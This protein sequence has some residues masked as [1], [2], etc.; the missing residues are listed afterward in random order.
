MR[1]YRFSVALLA[2]V[3]EKYTT[4]G[5]PG[6]VAASS[7]RMKL[8]EPSDSATVSLSCRPVYCSMCGS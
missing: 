3:S 8:N 2:P 4:P 7:I 5:V 6:S 1:P